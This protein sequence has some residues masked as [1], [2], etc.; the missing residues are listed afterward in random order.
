MQKILKNKYDLRQRGTQKS[1]MK[2]VRR[3]CSELKHAEYY[4][5][6]KITREE[7]R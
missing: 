3:K 5:S 1:K 6:Y 2:T 7:A 4:L